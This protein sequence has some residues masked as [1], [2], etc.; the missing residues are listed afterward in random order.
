MSSPPARYPA[1][2]VES[3]SSQVD[4]KN[5][6]SVTPLRPRYRLFWKYT[7]YF[8]ALV[9]I[10]LLT[11]GAFGLYFTYHET[12][13]AVVALQREK[14]LGAAIHIERFITEIEHQIGWND[15]PRIDG[16]AAL[17]QRHLDFIKLLRQAPAI[18]E[19]SW[20]D[21]EGREQLKVSRLA[22]DRLRSGA[23]LSTSP[24]FREAQ[25]QRPYFSPV[26]FRQQTEPYLTLAIASEHRAGGVIVAEVN[27]KF[28]WNVIAGIHVG[29]TGH[30]YVVD[31]RGQLISHPNISLV[32]QKTDLSKIPQVRAAL[33]QPASTGTPLRE[34]GDMHGLDDRPVLAAHAPI[35]PLG[36]VV[37]VEQPLNEAFEPLY[38]SLM[39]TTLLWIIGLVLS[40]AASL[41]LARHMVTP[42][43]ALQMGAARL[44][45]GRLDEHIEVDTH[46][47]LETLADEFNRMAVRLRESY[48]D[49]ERKIEKRTQELAAANQ[50]K[51]RFI[52][53][54]SHDLRQPMHALGLFVTQL[55]NRVT[56]LQTQHIAA[57]TEVAVETLQELFDAIL[58]VSRLDAGAVAPHITAFELHGFLERIVAGFTPAASH[59]GLHLRLVPTRLAVRG[60]L[61]FLERILINLLSNAVR[62]TERGGIVVGC[63][64]HGERVRVEVWDSGIGIPPEQ[65][66]AVFQEFYQTGNPEQDRRRGLGLGLA[67]AARLSQLLDSH[68]ELVSRPGKGSVFAFELPRVAAPAKS[69]AENASLAMDECLRGASILVVDDD[70]LVQEAMKSLL[71]HWGCSI[72]VAA[73]GDDAVATLAQCKRIPD[74]ILCDYRLSGNET[75]IEAIHR[76]RSAY[77]MQI[78]ATLVS[79]D[80]S[81]ERLREARQRGLTLLHKPVRPAKLRAL[82]EHL[83]GQ[84]A[85]GNKSAATVNPSG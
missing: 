15:Q 30:A 58:D 84:R 4:D 24:V 68:I 61:V 14:A 37:L 76:L 29:K 11:S 79:G 28:V 46:D 48:M 18:T 85:D 27:L 26:Y 66:L 41:A 52:A 33:A 67:I 62:Y 45:A 64:R 65:Q 40:I 75:G 7:V 3:G 12:R 23:D 6:E 70:S 5:E 9:S 69:L 72:T 60:D 80:T 31:D 50:A 57:Q 81:P 53:A 10:A 36:W 8:V 32:L 38:A 51:S 25:P 73:N 63:R 39:R 55:R 78:P 82:L 54:A 74:A 20:V 17:E 2:A 59:K 21:A 56:D 34:F 83:L 71:A 22:I 13:A 19:V 1:K 77:G 16:R 49:L 42:I 43:R 44:D 47:E 35:A